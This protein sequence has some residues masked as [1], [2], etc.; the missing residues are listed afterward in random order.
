MCNSNCFQTNPL[1]YFKVPLA[2]PE[3]GI[4]YSGKWTLDKTFVEQRLAGLN[5]MALQK[6]TSTGIDVVS[7]SF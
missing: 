1:P 5:P 6:V 4:V 7:N 3:L 2:K